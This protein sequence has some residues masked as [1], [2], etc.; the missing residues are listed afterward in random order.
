MKISKEGIN[1]LMTL[2]GKVK[3]GEL[4]FPYSDKTGKRVHEWSKDSTIGY[5]HLIRTPEEFDKFIGGIGEEEAINLKNNDL[6]K[7]NSFC[8][9]KLPET[10]SQNE[11]DACVI[12][13]YNI[14]LHEF[15]HNSSVFKWLTKVK[16]GRNFTCLED[17]WKAYRKQDGVVL[18]GLVNR[19]RKEWHMFID[20][21]YLA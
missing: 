13:C 4:H 9:T 17:A 19:R 3:S 12:F 16:E 8:E 11:F 20:G 15:E 2:E 18:Q 1:S 14:G 21:E 5:G 6:Q 7:F 10:L